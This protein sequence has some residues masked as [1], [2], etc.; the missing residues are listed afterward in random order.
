MTTFYRRMQMRHGIK[1]NTG[2][3]FDW[4]LVK[5]CFLVVAVAVAF[6][7]LLDRALAEPV[8]V[9]K[10]VKADTTCA[11]EGA[12]KKLAYDLHRRKEYKP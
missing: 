2:E 6:F 10:V 12:I 3:K 11:T 7:A 5:D 8:K 9:Y 1:W 4:S